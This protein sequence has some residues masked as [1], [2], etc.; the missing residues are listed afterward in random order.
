MYDGN[1]AHVRDSR[2]FRGSVENLRNDLVSFGAESPL[3]RT[4]FDNSCST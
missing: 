2:S 1:G 4:V 3:R